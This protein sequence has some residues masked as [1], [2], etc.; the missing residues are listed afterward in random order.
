MLPTFLE[1]KE[2]LIFISKN[3]Q[4]LEFIKV[5]PN[6]E[7]WEELANLKRIFY[8]FY[9]PSI[10]LQGSTYTTLLQALFYIYL[11]FKDLESLQEE[12]NLNQDKVSFFILFISIIY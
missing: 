2:V 4:N 12:F 3:T 9:K 1:L 7:E 8:I 5:F 11:I 10:K 6:T